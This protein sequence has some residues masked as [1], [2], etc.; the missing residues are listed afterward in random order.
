ML[1]DQ[2]C[3]NALPYWERRS[4]SLT[5]LVIDCCPKDGRGYLWTK[6]YTKQQGKIT[7]PVD[8]MPQVW[9]DFHHREMI[10]LIKYTH[11]TPPLYLLWK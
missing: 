9:S 8:L 4:A 2:H 6:E 7:Q 3:V 5:G 1:V 10:V 11:T